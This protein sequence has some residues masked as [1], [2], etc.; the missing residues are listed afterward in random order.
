MPQ[1]ATTGAVDV[2]TST[3]RGVSNQP[4]VV[5]RPTPRLAVTSVNPV[6]GH[7]G[8]T[9]TITG[10]GFEAT[11]TGNAVAFGLTRAR[12]IAASPSRLTAVVPDAAGSGPITV[13]TTSGASVTSAADFV[14]VP[15][16]YD[17]ATVQVG[18]RLVA[19]STPGRIDLDAGKVGFFRFYGM[20]GQ[21]LS[22][23]FTG[24]TFKGD[25]RVAPFT[26]YG[27]PFARAEY[28]APRSGKDL[29]GSYELPPLPTTGI[30]QIAVDAIDRGAG[31]AQAWLSAR[32]TGAVG[33]N[34]AR[35]PVRFDRPGQQT[36]LTLWA[37]A[38]QHVGLG[39]TPLG[40]RKLA[41]IGLA[42]RDP[43]GAPVP[44]DLQANTVAGTK[45]LDGS[46]GFT[47]TASRTGP[48]KVVV[49]SS[50]GNLGQMA[51]IASVARDVGSIDLR[52]G[53]SFSISRPGQGVILTYDGMV[54]QRLSLDFPNWRFAHDSYVTVLAP[55]RRPLWSDEAVGNHVDIPMLPATGRYKVLVNPW[56][57]TGSAIALLSPRREAGTVSA[58]GPAATVALSRPQQPVGLGFSASRGKGLAFAV[59]NWT[60]PARAKIRA[61]LISPEGS[62]EE[63]LDDVG[64]HSLFWYTPTAT[65]RHELVLMA[66][67]ASSVGSV[68][69]TL[70][71]GREGGTLPIGSTR[72]MSVARPGQQTRFTFAGTVGQRLTL[73]VASSTVAA[74][75]RVIWE[76]GSPD[77][78]LVVDA[79]VPESGL[80]IGPLPGS[81]TYE[82]NVY[83]LGGPG[84]AA[85][86]LSS[87]RM[88]SARPALYQQRS[89]NDQPISH[90]PHRI[91]PPS[92]PSRPGAGNAWTPDNRNLAGADWNTHLPAT[93][94]AGPVPLRAT[95]GATALSGIVKTLDGAPLPAVSVSAGATR[96][97]TDI[98]GRFLLGL[99]AGHHV[100][101]VDGAAANGPGRRFGLFDIG[102]DVAAGRTTVLPYPIWMSTLDVEHVVRFAAPATREVVITTPAIPGLEVHLPKGAVVR[103]TAGKPVTSLGITAIPID[104]PPFPL[105]N[106]R[107]PVYFTVQPGSAYVFPTGARVIY[108]NYTHARCGAVMDFWH[109]DPAG[110]GWFV[111][112]HGKV[113][114]DGRQ[115]VPD[116]GTEVYQFTGAMLIQPAG[117]AP[118]PTGPPPGGDATGADP[119]DLATGLMIGSQTDLRLDDTVPISVSRTYQQSD[120]SQRPFGTGYNLDYNMYLYSSKQW[121][122]GQLIL[123]NGSRITY[124]RT[125]TGGTAD[126]GYRN[127]VFAADPTPTPFA[128]SVLAWN[129]DGWD[130][131]LRNGTTYVFGE[132]APLQAVRDRYGNTVTITRAPASPDPDGVT[133][134]KGPIT[135][136]T[137]PHGRWIR[138]SY[139]ISE[140][141]TRA[142]DNLGRAIAYVYDGTGH[143]STVTD[144]TGAV[145]TYTYNKNGKLATIKDP[146]GAIAL[147]NVY[148]TAGRVAQQTLAD[149]ST[150]RIGYST[151]AWGAV[152]ATTLTDPRGIRRRVTFNGDGYSTSDTRAYGTDLAQT[153]AIVRD[154]KTNQP[155]AI[156]DALGRTT[157]LSYDPFGHVIARTD[158]AGTDQERTERHT[159]HGPYD[160]LSQQTDALG[161][162]TTYRYRG[163]ALSAITDPLGRT[164]RLA[165]GRDGQPTSITD[166]LGD[167]ITY[168]YLLGDQA[169]ITDPLGHTSRQVV[170]GAGRAVVAINPI[171]A[172]TSN[173]YDQDD[174]TIST[175]DPLGQITRYTYDTNGNL[176]Q[177][178]DPR[179]NSTTNTYDSRNRLI[180]S[181]DPL[182]RSW[183]YGYDRNGNRTA[184]TDARG[185]PTRYGYDALDRM[186]SARYDTTHGTP[187]SSISYAYDTGNRI[188]AINDSTGPSLTYTYD[189]F[190][191]IARASTGG[192]AFTYSYDNAGRRTAMS[193]GR[194]PSVSYSY[195]AA[196][197]LTDLTRDGD[198]V[199]I[200]YDGAGRRSAVSL[201]NG[202]TQNYRYDTSSRLTSIAYQRDQVRF[203]DLRYSYD[204]AGQLTSIEGR[205][206]NVSIPTTQAP[207]T[208]DAAN[209]LTAHGTTH[210]TYDANGNVTFDGRTKYNWNGRNQLAATASGAMATRYTYDAL[211]RRTS[212]T[213]GTSKTGYLHDG[214]NVAQELTGATPSAVLLTGGV[215]EVFARTNGDGTQSLLTDGLNNTIGVADASGT[216]SGMYTYQ[217]FG[218]T[219]VT[220]RD[221]G[222]P[223]RYAGRDDDGNGLY[224]YR[225]RYYSTTNQRFL[226]QDPIG[227]ASG[228]TNL[229]AYVGNRPTGYLDPLGTDPQPNESEQASSNRQT[230][231]FDRE[232]WMELQDR[233]GGSP[234]ENAT[235]PPL[236]TNRWRDLN[237]IRT[238]DCISGSLAPVRGTTAGI[239]PSEEFMVEKHLSCKYPQQLGFRESARGVR[240]AEALMV[241]IKL[242][243]AYHT[244][245]K[246]FD[247]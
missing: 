194:G 108:P 52:R 125:T 154:R 237:L 17:M 247:K 16:G 21:R 22:L 6:T 206:A 183:S 171:G 38:G 107:V 114:S 131:R 81:G 24:S 5:L 149:G 227:F 223:T 162:T 49:N 156:T 68:A 224:Y 204:A 145:T 3:G 51:V 174:R 216:V 14:A 10:S 205:L 77:R 31:S 128:G 34:G 57:S 45:G 203:G 178:T 15:R 208:Y 56:S 199:A 180:R 29:D 79:S 246:P 18:P 181:T 123:P 124:H 232:T 207:A 58:T 94:D 195:D 175:T 231:T 196:D 198:T 73:G 101:R 234:P 87:A 103:D 61:L 233:T 119:V 176:T 219:T 78:A 74:D 118:P 37:S 35:R 89:G 83:P 129:G 140:R 67:D 85:V 47:F 19:D 190:D 147:S 158:M 8:S 76:T 197:Q 189:A 65:G 151:G 90:T 146:R 167:T 20:K 32:K 148:D 116:K 160:Q 33:A 215:D 70:S 41:G 98:Q 159:Y 91:L 239:S 186:T 46:G 242:I 113:T 193:V 191:D 66:Q 144:P 141:I 235:E 115:V 11:P 163:A 168:G 133:R 9:I 64:S 221:G 142:E 169:T 7:A 172:T 105:P 99:P 39:F 222:N 75:A 130:V 92:K 100:L 200:R 210:L 60:L 138:F 201:P 243:D 109:Y 25:F 202:I 112:G 173:T 50:D 136:V 134:A 132:E 117:A 245:R 95:S 244:F 240:G 126:A 185:R 84:V 238:C 241:L 86:T 27:A 2:S 152:T 30:Y 137:S 97:T 164:T 13:A 26:P 110:R 153:T 40:A 230:F 36:E 212:K 59:S 82:V 179:G 225:S 4:F 139:D 1:G 43:D 69:I 54:G 48:Y 96:T 80:T 53:K 209:Q 166:N 157:Q 28:D 165:V 213:I 214:L 150:Y 93:G 106:S 121:L 218:A 211:G 55:N 104:R 62:V 71:N 187:E 184:V 226:S 72:V 122:D 12:V 177:V 155:V 161:R 135:Q 236:A 120:T 192:S 143:L 42:V 88:A 220:G 44:W 217:P 23:G 182:R 229:Y 127:A 188:T 102:V 111:Y 228:D 170:D 63:S